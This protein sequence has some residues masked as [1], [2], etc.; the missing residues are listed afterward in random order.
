MT[1]GSYSRRRSEFPQ[2]ED[3]AGIDTQDI[4]GKIYTR[5]GHAGFR[6]L[7]NDHFEDIQ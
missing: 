7:P 4:P 1:A 2:R 3:S 6:C 5:F